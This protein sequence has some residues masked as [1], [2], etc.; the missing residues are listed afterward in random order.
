MGRLGRGDKKVEMPGAAWQNE[1]KG[2]KKLGKK[3]EIDQIEN[4][5]AR[6]I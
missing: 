4:A 2:L 1:Q 3:W 6:T 5:L